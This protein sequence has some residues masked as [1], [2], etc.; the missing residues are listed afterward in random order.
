MRISNRTSIFQDSAHQSFISR[1]FNI[2]G[3]ENKFL[4]KNPSVLLALVQILVIWVF[5][6]KSFV[7][8]TP[9]YLMLSIF[10]NTVPSRVKEASILFT[11]LFVS[12]NMLHLTG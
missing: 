11:R 5:H 2:L 12:C 7:I 6:F 4:L 3:Q 10:S 9:R 1:F 8:V